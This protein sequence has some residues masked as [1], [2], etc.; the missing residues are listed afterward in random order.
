MSIPND[1]AGSPTSPLFRLAA[2]LAELV[3]AA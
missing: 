3:A 2:D 1:R